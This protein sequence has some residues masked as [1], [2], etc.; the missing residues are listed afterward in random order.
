MKH[1]EIILGIALL[2]LTLSVDAG[3]RE[4]CE[5]ALQGLGYNLSAYAF[6]EAGWVSKEK[7]I[8]NGTLVCFVNKNNEI[9]SIE[10]NSVLIAKDG[11]FGQDALAKRD[12]LNAERRKSIDEAKR[13]I[14]EQLEEIKQRINEKFDT[15]M[16]KVKMDSEPPETAAAREARERQI[17]A[18]RK[19]EEERIAKEKADAEEKKR[20]ADAIARQIRQLEVDEIEDRTG[21]T[22][23]LDISSENQKACADLLASHIEN[24]DVHSVQSESIWGGKFTVLYRDRYTNYSADQYNTRKCQISGG[25]V[26]ILSVFENWD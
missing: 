19:A 21:S 22:V 4:D 3:P 1:Q 20:K 6:E 26:R 9:H 25:T 11:F 5:T 10:D 12:K 2:T 24:I 23:S 15:E 13:K 7:H 16:Q 17:I 8:F 14:D 18:T